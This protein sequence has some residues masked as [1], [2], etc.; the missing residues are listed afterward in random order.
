VF[1]GKL[2][3]LKNLSYL[4]ILELH[5][6]LFAYFIYNT[7]PNYVITIISS[8]SISSLI[9]LALYSFLTTKPYYYYFYIGIIISSVPLMFIAYLSAVL[10]VP[11]LIILMILLTKGLEQ[12]SVYYKVRVNKNA[13]LS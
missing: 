12:G 5:T 8:L 11:E 9:I 13:N 10:I 2:S 1:K 7:L 3:F 6:F 4:I